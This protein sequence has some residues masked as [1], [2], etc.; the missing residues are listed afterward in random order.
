MPFEGEPQKFSWR[1]TQFAS[2]FLVWPINF[3]RPL[4]VSA[5]K[6]NQWDAFEVSVKNPFLFRDAKSFKMISR[7]EVTEAKIPKQRTDDWNSGS[8]AVAVKSATALTKSTF[9][10][11][12]SWQLYMGGL[13]QVWG[14][15]HT[16]QILAYLNEFDLELPA[17]VDAYF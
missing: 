15:V 6:K 4:A 3:E 16:V 13:S 14:M 10:V 8:K 5:G 7:T 17:L 9:V 2:T 1:A 11:T 12:V